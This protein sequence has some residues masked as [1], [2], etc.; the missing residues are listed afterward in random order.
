[1]QRAT[2]GPQSMLQGV[3]RHFSTC[4]YLRNI[5]SYCLL[6]RTQSS[7]SREMLSGQHVEIPRSWSVVNVTYEGP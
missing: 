1:M 6:K 2:T 4:S 3:K 5:A 7:A